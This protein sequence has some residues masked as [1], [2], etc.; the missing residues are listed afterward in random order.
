MSVNKQ[1]VSRQRLIVQQKLDK[2]NVFNDPVPPSGWIKAIR[3][4]L[5]LTIR[6]LAERVGVEH[7]SISQLE[8]REPLGKVTLESL[9]KVARAMNCKVVYAIVP[10]ETGLS[11]EGIVEKKAE[12]AAKR[13][14]QDVAHSMRLE[15][16]GTSEKETQKE[17]ARIARELL[18]SGDRRIWETDGKKLRG[19]KGA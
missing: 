11:L 16:Q 7:G 1:R 18:A 13:I 6:Q 15:K 8:K 17:I 19:K 4:A 2:A 14:L 10:A 3:G 5:G 9:E 12:E